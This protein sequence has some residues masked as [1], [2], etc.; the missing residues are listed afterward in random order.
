MTA[1]RPTA[2]HRARPRRR[3]GVALLLSAVMG[4]AACSSSPGTAPDGSGSTPGPVESSIGPGEA[5][6]VVPSEVPSEEIIR[7]GD[8]STSPAE[9]VLDLDGTPIATGTARCARAIDETTGDPT[10]RL[11]LAS[12]DGNDEAEVV[13]TDSDDPRVVSAVLMRG[14][15]VALAGAEGLDD[16]TLQA[17]RTGDEFSVS[18]SVRDQATGTTHELELRTTCQDL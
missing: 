12:A 13:V 15:E 8:P 17:S 14:D 9:A 2:P 10:V 4:L 7:G 1:A 6:S 11:L 5:P 18:G 16:S 3:L